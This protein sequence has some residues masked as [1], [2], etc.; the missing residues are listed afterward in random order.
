ML[1]V[2]LVKRVLRVLMVLWVQ[3]DLLVHVVLEVVQDPL[4]LSVHPVS[5]E[6]RVNA[7]RL[8]LQERRVLPVLRDPVVS[9]VPSEALECRVFKVLQALLVNLVNRVP[10]V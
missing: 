6:K 5:M 2:F 1:R 4:A 10:W 7:V 9:Q 3:L 8:V